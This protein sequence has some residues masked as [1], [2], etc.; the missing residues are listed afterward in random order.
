MRPFW[1]SLWAF[2]L[3]AAGLF[4]ATVSGMVQDEIRGRLG[5]VPYALIRLAVSRV[6]RDL[7]DDLGDEW[8]SEVA[9]ILKAAED[10]PVTGLVH[11]AWFA[12][13]LLL[14]SA[15]VAREFSGPAKHARDGRLHQVLL[16]RARDSKDFLGRLTAR[17]IV[18]QVV[19]DGAPGSGIAIRLRMKIA[20]AVVVAAAVAAAAVYTLSAQGPVYYEPYPAAHTI[21][22]QGYLPNAG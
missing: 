3:F 20:V 21:P 11:A 5:Q 6:P 19:L 8:R 2:A 1:A 16:R 9:G 13:G 22:G 7:R 4:V 15:A 17:G 10:V 14:R 18:R 12:V